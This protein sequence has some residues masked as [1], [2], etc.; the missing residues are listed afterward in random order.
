MNARTTPPATVH[1][2]QLLNLHSDLAVIHEYLVDGTISDIFINPD[3]KLWI[4][5]PG[6]GRSF[7]GK[8]IAPDITRRIINSTASLLGKT[9]Q[10]DHPVLEGVIPEYGARI[11]A[12]TEPWTLQPSIC[13]RKPT[14]KI[15]T[16]VDYVQDNRLPSA[17]NDAIYEAIMSRQNILIG[18]GTGTGKTTLLN[19]LINE[20]AIHRPKDRFFI[21][22]DTPEIRCL[23]E[24]YASLV[25]RP[26]E[27]VEA[28]RGA[29][30]YNPD[31]IVFGELRYGETALELLK[32]W[33]T[34][35]PGGFA[36][37]HAD[38]AERILPRVADLIA[39]H[40]TGTVQPGFLAESINLCIFLTDVPNFGP[41][42]VDLLRVDRTV[43]DGHFVFHHV[44]E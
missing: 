37:V 11:H 7:T 23:A 10:E 29:L 43:K 17:F 19:A 25:V 2:R 12:F 30:R 40:V 42:V 8:T 31:R 3:G 4:R 16:L 35:H 24:D 41:K 13:V 14:T 1:E 34:G 36:T 18:G 32:A 26:N 9:I 39:E 6:K 20:V 22:E 38:S 27:T 15:Y 5:Q 33:N 28:V 21:V 44:K